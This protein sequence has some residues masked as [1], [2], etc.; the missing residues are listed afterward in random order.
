M[1]GGLGSELSDRIDEILSITL[2]RQV[3]RP[4]MKEMCVTGRAVNETQE[5]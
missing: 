1:A 3:K 2:V 4:L 5:D